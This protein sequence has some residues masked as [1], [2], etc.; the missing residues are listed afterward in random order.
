MALREVEERATLTQ[1]AL[2]A[3]LNRNSSR[4]HALFT[5]WATAAR[6]EGASITAPSWSWCR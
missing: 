3:W 6:V 5:V 1:R 4:F 2:S